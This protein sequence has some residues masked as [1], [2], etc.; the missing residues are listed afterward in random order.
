MGY[1]R[2]FDVRIIVKMGP[3]LIGKD[4]Q[5]IA[6]KYEPDEKPFCSI[7]RNICY[8]RNICTHHD[9]LWNSSSKVQ[10]TIPR[11]PMDL[12]LSANMQLQHRYYNSLV[13][14]GQLVKLIFPKTNWHT[15]QIAL[16][17]KYP[18]VELSAI[19]SPEDWRERP[20]WQQS[21]EIY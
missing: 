20:L 19:G 2:S 4:R 1:R 15:D 16:A 14:M 18:R 21:S 8:I 5:A 9:R 12:Y 13:I 17:E 10:L 7:M 11:F 6:R 3:N